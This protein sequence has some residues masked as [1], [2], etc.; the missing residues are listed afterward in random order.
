VHQRA[1][2]VYFIRRLSLNSLTYTPG[3]QSCSRLGPTNW[4][5][6]TDQGRGSSDLIQS[7]LSVSRSS[8]S[9]LLHT[10][11]SL[12]HSWARCCSFLFGQVEIHVIICRN[13]TVSLCAPLIWHC[14]GRRRRGPTHAW[15]MMNTTMA[16]MDQERHISLEE[17]RRRH[18]S[19]HKSPVRRRDGRKGDGENRRD[20]SAG[21]AGSG[22]NPGSDGNG[23]LD[24]KGGGN[25]NDSNG[26]NDKGNENND[27]RKVDNPPPFL[28]SS[29]T[30]VS[31]TSA[32]TVVVVSTTTAPAPAAL[33]TSASSPT[34]ATSTTPTEVSSTK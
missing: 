16:P 27:N 32:T 31:T 15:Q 18:D 2:P 24:G 3:L 8:S 33:T 5:S 28:P 22:G 12:I 6:V 17:L 25:G 34:S 26:S 30:K 23:A 21:G 20:V 1:L 7:W 4:A 13:F 14:G 11:G 19:L 9:L 10:T 29:P